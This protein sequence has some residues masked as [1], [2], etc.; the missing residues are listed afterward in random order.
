MK[1][2]G[3]NDDLIQHARGESTHYGSGNKDNAFVSTSSKEELANEWARLQLFHPSNRDK[4][5][6]Y[7][8]TIQANQD[9][10]NLCESLMTAFDP[11]KPKDESYKKVAT[12]SANV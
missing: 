3:Q 12:G 4:K 10:Y 6:I 8:F 5:F 7:V 1:S 11:T 9:F 2:L